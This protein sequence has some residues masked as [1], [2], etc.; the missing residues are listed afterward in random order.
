M[1]AKLNLTFETENS[2]QA[3]EIIHFI[4]LV[5]NVNGFENILETMQESITDN[6]QPTGQLKLV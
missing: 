4:K 1:T 2:K 3:E 6:S 5:L